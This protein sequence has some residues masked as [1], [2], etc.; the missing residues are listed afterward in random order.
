MHYYLEGFNDHCREYRLWS[1]ND[2]LRNYLNLQRRSSSS[3]N[4]RSEYLLYC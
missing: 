1:R 4:H 2:C 3:R